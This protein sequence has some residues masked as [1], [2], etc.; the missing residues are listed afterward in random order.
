MEKDEFGPLYFEHSQNVQ[1]RIKGGKMIKWLYRNLK[2]LH[3]KRHHWKSEKLRMGKNICKL[4]CD[5][6]PIFKIHTEFLQSVRQ[7]IQFNNGQRISIGISSQKTY[8]WRTSTWKDTQHKQ[9]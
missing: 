9:H 1:N 3:F 2:F 8:K 4:S 7:I 5:Y 6:G